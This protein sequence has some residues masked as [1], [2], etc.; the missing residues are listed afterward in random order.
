MLALTHVHSVLLHL[1]LVFMVHGPHVTIEEAGGIRDR[2]T[3]VTVER[4]EPQACHGT[5]RQTQA[6]GQTAGES[7][8]TPLGK[9]CG[10]GPQLPHFAT[11]EAEVEATVGEG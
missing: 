1:P 4:K 6:A 7:G 8:I 2:V 9:G 3:T 10:R 11:V 5:P